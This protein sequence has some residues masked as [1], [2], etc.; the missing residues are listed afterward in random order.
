MI[1]PE[2][3]GDHMVNE[4]Y[5]GQENKAKMSVVLVFQW[6]FPIHK[7]RPFSYEN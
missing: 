4:I 3:F 6:K 2:M 7:I 5:R 1:K